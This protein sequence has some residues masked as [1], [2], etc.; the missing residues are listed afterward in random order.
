MDYRDPSHAKA[1]RGRL[2]HD[3]AT[4][5]AHENAALALGVETGNDQQRSRA[6]W[7]DELQP[8]RSEAVRAPRRPW[9]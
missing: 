8:I 3:S 6:G 9:T 7:I 1:V 2:E 4:R 5:V